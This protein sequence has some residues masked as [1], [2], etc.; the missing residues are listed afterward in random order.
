MNDS[1]SSRGITLRHLRF[2]LPARALTNSSAVTVLAESPTA[3]RTV[4]FGF[5]EPVSF[6]LCLWSLRGAKVLL[7]EKNAPGG[8][9]GIEL[10]D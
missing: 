10:Q 7:L 3:P 9:A 5:K 6:T 1:L 2:A 8:Q 4:A